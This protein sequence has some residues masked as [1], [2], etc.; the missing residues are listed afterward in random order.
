MLCSSEQRIDSKLIETTV[1]NQ[2]STI[3]TYV[4]LSTH[5]SSFG[6]PHTHDQ[7]PLK[8]RSASDMG[9]AEGHS[10]GA[11]IHMQIGRM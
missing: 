2:Q 11:S 8:E 6:L 7:F 10:T 5:H 4:E 3:A 9:V 1:N